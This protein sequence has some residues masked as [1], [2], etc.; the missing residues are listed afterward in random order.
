MAR[1]KCFYCNTKVEID[2]WND[3]LDSHLPAPYAIS[4]YSDK[5]A[6]MS[7]IVEPNGPHYQELPVQPKPEV[8]RQAVRE[9]SGGTMRQG[10]YPTS[11]ELEEFIKANVQ[12]ESTE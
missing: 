4:Y 12:A 6:L 3:H 9:A 7:K 1:I 8:M 2:D 10:F 5:P 11:A